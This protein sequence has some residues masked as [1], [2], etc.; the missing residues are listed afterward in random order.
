[1]SDLACYMGHDLK[2]NRQCRRCG[3]WIDPTPPDAIGK[4]VQFEAYFAGGACKPPRVLPTWEECSNV[5][6]SKRSAVQQLVYDTQF[7]VMHPDDLAQFRADLAAA[8]T[9]ETGKPWLAEAEK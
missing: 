3:K 7:M 8:L 5:H 6:E 9:E 1:M 2:P 4:A